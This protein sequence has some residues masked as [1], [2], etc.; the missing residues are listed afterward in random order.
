MSLKKKAVEKSP[1]DEQFIVGKLDAIKR[2]A[3]RFLL[4]A[5]NYTDFEERSASGNR[6]Q[7]KRI[8]LTNYAANVHREINCE[9]SANTNSDNIISKLTP[10]C[11]NSSTI[12]QT[13]HTLSLPLTALE[14]S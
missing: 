3:K 6:T 9:H 4:N 11:C 1:Y 14:N 10:N 8:H 5:K 7:M 13:T 12:N 2:S